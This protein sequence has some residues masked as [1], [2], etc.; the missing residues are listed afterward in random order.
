MPYIQSQNTKAQQLSAQAASSAT[1]GDSLLVG[2]NA[3][4][5]LWGVPMLADNITAERFDFD[6]EFGLRGFELARLSGTFEELKRYN[7]PLLVPLTEEQG[8]GYLAVLGEDSSD[9]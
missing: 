4:F 6:R 1:P 5:A 2:T 8:G 7:L 3:L 9:R